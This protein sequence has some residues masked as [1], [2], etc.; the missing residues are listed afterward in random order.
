MIKRFGKYVSLV[1]EKIKLRPVGPGNLRL[2]Q[3]TFYLQE[4]VVDIQLQHLVVNLGAEDVADP[5]L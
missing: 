3:K 2:A 5:V 4:I 1:D